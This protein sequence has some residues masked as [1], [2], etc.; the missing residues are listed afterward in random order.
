MV[1]T[2]QFI[3]VKRRRD[4]ESVQA[5]LVDEEQK[6]RK[7]RYVFKLSRTIQ[8]NESLKY[9]KEEASLIADNHNNNRQFLLETS[10]YKKRK[11]LDSGFDATESTSDGLPSDIMKMVDK[12]LENQ[13][14]S[15]NNDVQNRKRSK[16]H[17]K[18]EAAK[19]LP[20]PSLDYVYD[21]YHLEHVKD[22]SEYQDYSKRPDVAYLKIINRDMDLIPD[23]DTDDNRIVLSDDE[24]SN[25]ENYYKNDYP[26]DED[27][28]RSILFGSEEDDFASENEPDTL[29]QKRIDLSE[30]NSN[31]ECPVNLDER[32]TSNYSDIF[33]RLENSSNI[34]ESMNNANVVDL[35]GVEDMAYEYTDE[36]IENYYNSEGV[37]S[38]DSHNGTENTLSY[39]YM[40]TDADNP[41][42]EHRDRIFHKLQRMI[43]RKK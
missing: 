25:D 22:E 12:Y 43:D 36:E 24:D 30:Q 1:Q 8:L 31:G 37:I 38:H 9:G 3:R 27:D 13:S 28:D 5:L 14:D 4:D 32:L 21:I 33:E 16:K 23:E 20:L 26:E 7:K 18:G 40:S 41:L 6:H 34:L 29:F 15:T 35:D 42:A 10:N 19:V 2:P 39:Q 17:F 11:L